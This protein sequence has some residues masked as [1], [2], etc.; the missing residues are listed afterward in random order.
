MSAVSRVVIKNALGLGLFA[1]VTAGLVALTQQLTAD[2]IAVQKRR[3]QASA[4]LEVIPRAYH[5]N[6]LAE[7]AFTIA[8]NPAL[9]FQKSGTG[10]RAL[11]DGAVSAVILPV[12]APDGYAG[13]IRLILG[14][15][16]SGRLLGVRVLDHHETPG[17]GDQI[18]TRKSDWILG[19]TGHS[20]GNPEPDGWQVRKHGGE[21]DQFTGATITPSAVVRAV[22]RAL[23]YFH[24]HQEV[25]FDK[26]VSAVGDGGG[27]PRKNSTERKIEHGSRHAA[28]DPTRQPYQDSM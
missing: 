28:P 1:M 7:S 12:V 9:G 5:D 8:P 11:R 22:R 23:A 20:L 6:E 25:L 17:L 26:S 3:A 21:F 2:D 19:F 18:E 16:R 27:A 10:Y 14:I 24:A 13:A 4:L 15:D